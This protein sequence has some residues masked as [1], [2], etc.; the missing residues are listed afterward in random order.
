MSMSVYGPF[1]GIGP[2]DMLPLL[3]A[4]AYN[5]HYIVCHP[6]LKEKNIGKFNFP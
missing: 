1:C 2:L 5:C 3:I 6:L 4:V